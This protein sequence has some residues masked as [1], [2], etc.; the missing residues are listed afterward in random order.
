MYPREIKTYVSHKSL[1]MIIHS[2]MICNSPNLETAQSADLWCTVYSLPWNILR[3]KKEHTTGTGSSLDESQK[4]YAAWGEMMENK[5]A[6]A[7]V[8]PNGGR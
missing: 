4:P 3:N 5:L 7:G 6:A 2:T 1:Y 8:G